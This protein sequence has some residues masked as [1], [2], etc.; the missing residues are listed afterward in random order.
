MGGGKAGAVG[1]V[2]G[3]IIGIFVHWLAII[4]LPF[5]LAV[6]FEVIAGR[7]TGHAF[8]AGTGAWIGL[9]VGGVFRFAIGCIMIGLFLWNV[10]L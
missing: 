8:K 7:R 1:A 2:L 4:I 6:L 9:L 5:L 10:I 3:L